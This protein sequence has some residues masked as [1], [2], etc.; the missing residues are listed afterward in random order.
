MG[1]TTK[2]A[3][4]FIP[5][6]MSLSACRHAEKPEADGV[7]FSISDAMMKRCELTKASTEVVKNELNLFGKIAPDN[8]RQATIYP[9][10]GGSVIKIFAELGDNVKQGQTL[11]IIRSGEVADFQRQLLDARADL[12]LAEKNV[13]V[14]RELFAGKINSERDVIAA[15]KEYEKA[16]A[17]L[18]RIEEVYRIYGL[19]EGSLYNITAPISGFIVFKNITQNE[20]LRSDNTSAIFSIAQIDEVWVLANVNESD[21]SKVQVGFEAEVKTIS[22]PD[23][24]FKGRVDRIFN[25][26]D[27]STKAMKILVK[28]HN[29][30]LLLKPDM[31]AT[32]V[33]K[34]EENKKLISIPSS[35]VIFD[36]SKY[37]VMVFKDRTNI[38]TRQVEIYRQLGNVTYV[39]SGLHEGEVVISQNGLMIYDALND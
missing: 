28:I 15:Q 10:M 17:E 25:A 35:S 13:S 38:E 4:L 21:I 5:V 32:I 33:L 29:G 20:Q 6:I 7:V 30:D 16:R 19:R 37:W 36:K 9:I 8:S 2:T 18:D 39:L 27:P 1:L 3:L 14:A 26:I 23:R 12:A 22:Y 24:I 11:A 34:Y 31:N